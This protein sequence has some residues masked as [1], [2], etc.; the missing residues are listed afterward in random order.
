MYDTCSENRVAE[1]VRGKP[2]C[3]GWKK[4]GCPQALGS[5]S[6]S[7]L[8][9]SGRSLHVAQTWDRRA[10]RPQQPHPMV[11]KVVTKMGVKC[12]SQKLVKSASVNA[13]WNLW[14]EMHSPVFLLSPH[15][16]W[17]SPS[18][19][20][21]CAKHSVISWETGFPLGEC[22]QVLHWPSALSVMS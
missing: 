2:S 5:S 20:H 16:P 21:M 18:R 1:N 17:T 19:G 15:A 12:G 9:P 10:S 4:E 14:E 11:L 8:C 7:S 22:W 13:L 6:A 3:D